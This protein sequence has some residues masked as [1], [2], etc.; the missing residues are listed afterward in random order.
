MSSVTDLSLGTAFATQNTDT[1][2][3]YAVNTV[4]NTLIGWRKAGSSYATSYILT[5]GRKLPQKGSK[6]RRVTVKLVV[7]LV[8]TVDSIDTSP[9]A[10]TCVTDVIIPVDA[11]TGEIN[12]SIAQHVNALLDSAIKAAFTDSFPY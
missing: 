7:P 3:S 1:P 4:S 5:L 11:T 2:G 9:F 8:R 12:G 6:V 10:I